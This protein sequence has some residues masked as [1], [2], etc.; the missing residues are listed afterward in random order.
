M[1]N[2]RLE[3]AKEIVK[4]H[5][6]EWLGTG[7]SY[8][9]TLVSDKLKEKSLI[10]AM[11]DAGWRVA[12]NN[13]EGFVDFA[14]AMTSKGQELISNAKAHEDVYEERAS[15]SWLKIDKTN[16]YY[17]SW[18]LLPFLA[19]QDYTVPLNDIKYF[20]RFTVRCN[21]GL[22]VFGKDRVELFTFAAGNM[23]MVTKLFKK[24]GIIQINQR[25][26]SASERTRV[27]WGGIV[28]FTI[29]IIIA[30][31]TNWAQSHAH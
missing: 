18:S 19:K 25:Q 13:D 28:F 2:P 23:G 22:S 8:I 29:L 5:G 11:N 7:D 31:I 30:I 6:A 4:A 10:A 3:K 20:C 16:I 26:V 17:K 14:D 24:R 12:E 21:E 27:F 9:S 15:F 1:E